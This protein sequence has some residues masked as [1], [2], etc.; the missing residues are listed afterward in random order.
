[1]GMSSEPL[2]VGCCVF[3]GQEPGARA[4]DKADSALGGG[5]KTGSVEG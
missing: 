5:V 4:Q 3:E 1:M 2:S